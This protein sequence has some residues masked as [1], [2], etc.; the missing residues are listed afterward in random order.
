MGHGDTDHMSPALGQFCRNTLGRHV[1]A[2]QELKEKL[3]LY[4]ATAKQGDPLRCVCVCMYHVCACVCVCVMNTHII[5]YRVCGRT[6][7][8]SDSLLESVLASTGAVEVGQAS[9]CGK[10]LFAM[11]SVGDPVIDKV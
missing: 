7:G 11:L 10:H 4:Q 3:L 6:R 1:L 2:L 5:L 8:V 9:G